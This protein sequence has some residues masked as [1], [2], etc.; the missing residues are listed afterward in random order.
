MDRGFQIEHLGALIDLLR[1]RGVRRF[2]GPLTVRVME[3]GVDVG[4]LTEVMEIE[5]VECPR[6]AGCE[7]D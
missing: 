2:S 3:H 7:H 1:A 5:L 4:S 6:C